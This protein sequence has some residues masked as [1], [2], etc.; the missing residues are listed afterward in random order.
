MLQL[1]RRQLAGV[2]KRLGSLLSGDAGSGRGGVLVRGWWP[3]VQRSY[4]TVGISPKRLLSYL[5]AADAGRPQMQFELFDEMLA[6][7]PRLAAVESTRRLALTGL[8]WEVVPAAPPGAGPQVLKQAQQAAAY[9]QEVL[10]SLERFRDG[11]SHLAQAVGYGIAVAELVWEGSRLVDIVPVPHSRLCADPREPWRLRVLV[12]SEP[13]VG[14][15]VDEQPYKWM[16]HRFRAAGPGLFSGGLLRTSALL[17]V[18]QNLSLKDWLIYSQVAGMPIRVAQF[19]PGT[20]EGDKQELLR[21]LESLGTEAVAVL[22][23][24]VDLRFVEPARGASS[25][26]EALQDYCN[27]EVTIL[28]LGQHLTTD[29]R[30]SGSRAAAEIHDRVREDLLVEDIA[31]EGQTVR[32]D[33]LAPLVR[34]RFGDGVPVPFF[35]RSLLQSVDTRVLAQTLA[36]AVREL[37]LSVP[38]AWVHQALGI[39]Q[40]RDNEPIV[41]RE[42]GP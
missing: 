20:P 42:V 28:W 37:G 9:C 41:G 1:A 16:V 3:D 12:E 29:I 15:A 11:L 4:P 32:R 38:R 26:Y 23:K 18:S 39:P 24:N 40:P 34:A 22:S 31:A 36:V 6:K 21:M 17:F 14:V 27:T 25:L 8:D 10:L 33:L 19:E 7:W 2:F 35:R 5:Q 30:Q 13:D